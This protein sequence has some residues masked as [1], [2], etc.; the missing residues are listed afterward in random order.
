MRTTSRADVVVVGLGTMG[1]MALW[2]LAERGLTAVGFEQHGLVHTYGSFTGE[3]RLFRTAYHESPRYVPMLLAARELWLELERKSGR[4]LFLPVGA[5]SIGH[6]DDAAIGNVLAS[7]RENDIP[8]DLFDAAALR[9]RY[10][11]HAVGDDVVAVLDRLG[12]GLRPEASVLA[13]LEL[14]RGAGAQIHDHEAVVDITERADDVVVETPHHTVTADAVVV[15]CGSWTAA[16]DPRVAAVANVKPLLLTWFVPRDVGAYGPDRFPVFIR[17]EPGVHFF[18]APSLDGFSVKMSTAS[19]WDFVPRPEDVPHRLSREEEVLI[20][21]RA[22]SFL[23][24]L[25]PVPV[26]YSFHH[27]LYT[28][29]KRPIIDRTGRVITL[30]GF[31]GH[32]FKFAP[33]MGRIAA[34]LAVAG[35]SELAGDEYALGTHTP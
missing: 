8:H 6:E 34:E 27:D 7:V 35:H 11:Q 32:G 16:L 19:R 28:A 14:A 30:A 4:A 15:T 31:S 17:D 1:S 21:R 22:Q 13:A 23:P 5:L 10:P 24:D 20:G 3:S 33:V 18:G 29:D 25:H 2:Q 9:A 12:G 26:R